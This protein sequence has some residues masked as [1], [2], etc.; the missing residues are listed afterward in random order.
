MTDNKYPKNVMSGDTLM[1]QHGS[2]SFTFAKEPIGEAPHV[3]LSEKLRETAE[4]LRHVP[5]T[6]DIYDDD[7]DALLEAAQLIRENRGFDAVA[8]KHELKV[9]TEDRD[10][11]FERQ[12]SSRPI[13]EHGPNLLFLK[14]I[15]HVREREG[16]IDYPINPGVEFTDQ[17]RTKLRNLAEQSDE[18]Y[19]TT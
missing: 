10:E 7:I 12:L 11:I 18:L 14:Y 8:I 9:M 5:G 1:V 2:S 3:E 19:P 4:K 16:A 6:Y 17:E 13:D 15:A